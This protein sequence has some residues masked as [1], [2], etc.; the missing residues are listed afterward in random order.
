MTP[1]ITTSHRTSNP[2]EAVFGYS[3]AVRR[4]NQ[5]FVSGT[6]SVSTSS[7]SSSSSPTPIILHAGDA[8]QQTTT[9]LHESIC[10]IEKLG[11]KKE[12]V[13]RV[14]L[15]G[16]AWAATM[17]VGVSFVSEEMLVEVELDAV[18]G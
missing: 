10:A 9:A 1:L 2:Y 4:G 12:D 3:R 11:G 16:A 14:K 18:V 5:I 15:F 6:T 13:V 17:I 8:Y 7:S